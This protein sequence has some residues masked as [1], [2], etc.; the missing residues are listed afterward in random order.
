[1]SKSNEKKETGLHRGRIQAQ[2]GGVEKS[3]SWLQDTFLTLADGKK[4]IEKLKNKL[5]KTE[6]KIRQK[7]FQKLEKFVEEHSETGISA[8]SLGHSWKVKDSKNERVDLEIHSGLAFK[9]DKK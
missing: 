8:P 2:G 7:E 5:T 6:L 3:E 1:M 9:D 4:L